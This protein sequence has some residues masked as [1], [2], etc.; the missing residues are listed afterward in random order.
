M[1]KLIGRSA[2]TLIFMFGILGC[3][4]HTK[5]VQKQNIGFTAPGDLKHEALIVFYRKGG[6]KADVPTVW[7]E[8]RI[9]GALMPNQYAQSWSC[10]RRVTIH[11]KN[12][13][14]IT[15]HSI[16]APKGEILYVE[17][18]KKRN[19]TFAIKKTKGM[20]KSITNRSDAMN[21]YKPYCGS[22]Y[23]EL[24]ADTLFAFNQSTLSQVGKNTIDALAKK[25][26]A[27]YVNI[28]KIRIEG[29]TDRIG[30]NEYNN[31]L[32]DARA[33]TVANRLKRINPGVRMEARGMG[34]RYPVTKGCIGDTPT[35]ELI[36]CLAPDR[37][38][39]VEIIGI[40]N[41]TH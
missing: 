10:P 12:G 16:I 29:H 20:S 21:R 32:S 40:Q 3:A 2:L 11:I 37:R 36:E 8:D 38:V 31:D 23:I 33:R 26:K 5:T 39:S 15:K 14:N 19:G 35:A 24:N 30:T 6:S 34:E 4:T 17:V 1:K 22:E 9:V 27:G 25:I 7:L 13:S 28:K 41:D 18:Y